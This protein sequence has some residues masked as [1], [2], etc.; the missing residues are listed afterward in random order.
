[1]EVVTCALFLILSGWQMAG[2]EPIGLP[3]NGDFPKV[4]AALNIG[5]APQEVK[6]VGSDRYFAPSFLIDRKFHWEAGLPSSEFWLAKTAKRLSLWFLPS[7]HFDLR[8]M[9]VVHALILMLAL[10]LILRT[11]RTEPLWLAGLAG[12]L[13]LFIFTDVEYVQFFSTAY[14]DAASIVFFC[15]LAAVG[16]NLGRASARISLGWAFGFTAAGCLFL[17]SKLQHQLAV[18]PLCVLAGVFA[19]RASAKKVRGCFIFAIVAF[20]AATVWMA[21]NTRSDYRA[22]PVYNLLFMRLAP[23]S[24]PPVK[25]LQEFGMPAQYSQYVGKLPF[26]QGYVL[27]DMTERRFFV[28]QVTLGAIVGYYRRHPDVA[29]HFLDNDLREFAPDVDLSGWPGVYRFRLTDYQQHR[30]NRH[31]AGWSSMR[32]MIQANFFV[33]IPMLYLTA[34]ITCFLAATRTKFTRAFESWPVL[35]FLTL[36]GAITFFVVALNDCL[37]SSRHI[38]IFQV[39]TDLILFLLITGVVKYLSLNL[40]AQHSTANH[41]KSQ[42]ENSLDSIATK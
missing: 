6:E 27:N 1:M 36:V 20:V 32:R 10:W 30:T 11:Y 34:F 8:M 31:F 17:T 39:A 35:G 12:L 14:A 4:L 22:D 18:V 19:F 26:Q 38:I 3:D 29:W 25:V 42:A 33:F 23:Y 28:N 15:V 2:P 7:G 41:F 5:H 9:G 13:L 37:E 24:K 16:L 40:R 21:K